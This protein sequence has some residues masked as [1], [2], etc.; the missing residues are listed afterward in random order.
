MP[1]LTSLT[2]SILLDFGIISGKANQPKVKHS[3]LSYYNW[4]GYSE[5]VPGY[6]GKDADD[7]S[8]SCKTKR[9]KSSI[10]LTLLHFIDMC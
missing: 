1:T 5:R 4:L 7:C 6:C 3:H 10:R 8:D 9:E 2:A